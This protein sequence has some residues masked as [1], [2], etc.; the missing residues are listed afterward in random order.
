M[1]PLPEIWDALV[2][3]IST[4][5]ANVLSPTLANVAARV[6]SLNVSAV[7]LVPV[8]RVRSVPA[9]LVIEFTEVSEGGSDNVTAPVWAVVTPLTR[10]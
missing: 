2:L 7:P 8:P 6:V 10:T 9:V 4:D 5:P 3:P 1:F